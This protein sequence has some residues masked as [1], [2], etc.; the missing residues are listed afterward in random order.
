MTD[1]QVAQRVADRLLGRDTRGTSLHNLT[2]MLKDVYAGH[3][4]KQLEMS[5]AMFTKL[6]AAKSQHIA[7]L[8]DSSASIPICVSSNVPNDQ[9]WMATKDGKAIKVDI[10]GGQ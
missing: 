4:V 1:E 8:I 6:S 5:S 7:T 10:I 3:I 2:K 9:I